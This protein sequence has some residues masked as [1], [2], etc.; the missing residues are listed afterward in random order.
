MRSYF[1]VILA[2]AVL[3]SR[4][5]AVTVDPQKSQNLV[6]S[7]DAAGMETRSRKL[8]R[9]QT[10]NNHASGPVDEERAVVPDV[11]KKLGSGVSKW[12]GNKTLSAKLMWYAA[13]VDLDRRVQK[14]LKQGYDPNSVYKRLHLD[15]RSVGAD[16]PPPEFNLWFKFAA[17]YKDK[18][19][20]WVSKFDGVV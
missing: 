5:T 6:Q 9:A 4:G 15:S 3:I 19:P 16:P 17:A 20:N 12:A 18:N 13:Q 10:T 2:V 8:L 11:L 7:I 14:L 1:V